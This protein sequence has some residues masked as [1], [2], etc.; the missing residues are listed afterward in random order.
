MEW[1]IKNRRSEHLDELIEK[2]L[3]DQKDVREVTSD[4]ISKRERV[5]KSLLFSDD[6]ECHSISQRI[7]DCKKFQTKQRQKTKP[8]VGVT[9]DDGRKLDPFRDVK[10]YVGKYVNNKEVCRLFGVPIV[11]NSYRNVWE[12]IEGTTNSKTSS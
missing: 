11:G 10:G 1:K 12:P 2:S 5:S 6:K 7:K 4:K 8:F 9:L 3:D